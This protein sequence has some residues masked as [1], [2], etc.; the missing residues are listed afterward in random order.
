VGFIELKQVS[1]LYPGKKEPVL[2]SVSH[3]FDKEGIT[4]VVG[5]N[6]SG[7]TTLTKIMV[8]IVQPNSGEIFLDSLP[9][10]KYTLAEIG[11]H[12]GYVF[13]NPSHQFFCTTVAEEIGFGLKHLGKEPEVVEEKVEFYLKYFE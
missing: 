10:K 12:I 2:N 4:A 8:G 1:F 13:Q 5:A 9:L 3:S 11:R 7:K 6:G